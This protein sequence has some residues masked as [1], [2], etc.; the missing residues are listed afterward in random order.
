MSISTEWRSLLLVEYSK[1]KFSCDLLD[2][3]I[4]DDRYMVIENIIYYNNRI[5]IVP[6]LTLKKKLLQALHDSP[7]SG[8]QELLKTY[9]QI[10]ENVLMER[11]QGGVIQHV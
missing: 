8:H 2:R 10:R 6:E 1:K 5:Y 3:K 7:L 4:H 11:P 9:R